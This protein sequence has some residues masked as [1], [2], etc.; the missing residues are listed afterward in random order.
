MTK[1]FLEKNQIF[2]VLAPENRS[3]LSKLDIF[4]SI[5]S[6]STYLLS[7]AKS[8]PSGWVCF[9]E[10]QTR[11][12][13]RLGRAWF[14]P[15]AENIYCSMLWR[16]SSGQDISGLGIAIGVIVAN[17]LKKYGAG[18]IKL[19]WPND[20]LFNEKKLA[21]ILL[22]SI[23]SSVV[24]G[25]G[26][27]LTLHKNSE[28]NWTALDEI[29]GQPI[30]R[31]FFAGL[32]VNELLKKLPIYQSHGLTEFLNEWRE[33]DF[34][35]GKKIVIHLPD[36]KIIGVMEGINKNGELLLRNEKN[37]LEHF[38]YGEVSVRLDESK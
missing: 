2:S 28:K 38:R 4:D 3:L 6:T 1:E 31:N 24:I 33:Y 18:N 37:E 23:G 12:R 21:G 14:S 13:G 10:Q 15:Y 22:E 16:F 11:G 29:I 36:K 19:K 35:F 30:K 17:T 32:L 25:I 8:G 20:I 9:A 34:L 7:Q 26:I 27:N 5:D